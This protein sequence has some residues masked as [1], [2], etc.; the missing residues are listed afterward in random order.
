MLSGRLPHWN[1]F[2]ACP[3]RGNGCWLPR[4]RAFSFSLGMQI[5]VFNTSPAPNWIA[6]VEQENACFHQPLL[7]VQGQSMEARATVDLGTVHHSWQGEHLSQMPWCV[8]CPW[9]KREH[10]IKSESKTSSVTHIRILSKVAEVTSR[11]VLGLEMVFL[12]LSWC[13]GSY[14]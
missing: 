10:I 3:K 2:L 1:N 11:D 4:R 14:E 12:S 9:Q 7:W 8:D 6:S 5:A 13:N